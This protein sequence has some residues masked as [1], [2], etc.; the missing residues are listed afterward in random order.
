MY[1]CR[2]SGRLIKYVVIKSLSG[3]RPRDGRPRQRWL[4]R[5]NEDVKADDESARIEDAYIEI[6][7]VETAKR[8]VKLNIKMHEYETYF[9]KKKKRKYD[10]TCPEYYCMSRYVPVF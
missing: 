8:L 3:K 10:T 4:D 2:A 5:V 1:L 6:N 9:R 7:S